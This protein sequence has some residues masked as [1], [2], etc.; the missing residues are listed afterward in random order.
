MNSYTMETIARQRMTETAH[1]AATVGARSQTT[2]RIRVRVTWAVPTIV[3]VS[4][5]EVR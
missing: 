1:R 2:R 5:K 4:T 3:H